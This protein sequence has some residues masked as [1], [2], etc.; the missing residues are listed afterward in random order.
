M[1][2]QLFFQTRKM[3][4]ILETVLLPKL[5]NIECFKSYFLIHAFSMKA[6]K[7]LW[8]LEHYILCIF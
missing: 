6:V 2:L 7:F 5:E 1:L 4:K 8:K 3:N